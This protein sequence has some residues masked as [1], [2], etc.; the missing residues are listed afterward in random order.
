[1]Y[2]ELFRKIDILYIILD[3]RIGNLVVVQKSAETAAA[4]QSHLTLVVRYMYSTPPAFGARIVDTVLNTE[5]LH[6]EWME[7]IRTMSSRIISMRTALFDALTALNTPGTWNHV[8]DQ[9]GMFS[10]TGLS[11]AQVEYLVNNHHIYL[12]SSG[13][14]N[15]CGLNES[16]VEYVA[17]AIHAAVTT[18][19]E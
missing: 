4:I 9:I 16:N 15:M 12:L 7:S 3:E 6:A 14:I 8:T 10:Y 13:R 18:I 5:D 11:R 17:K 19:T 2:L 1:M